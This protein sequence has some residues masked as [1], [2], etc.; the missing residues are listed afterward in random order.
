MDFLTERCIFFFNSFIKVCLDKA[1]PIQSEF[2][3]KIHLNTAIR[4]TKQGERQ[5]KIIQ[6]L[7]A[8]SCDEED[9]DSLLQILNSIESNILFPNDFLPFQLN[10]RK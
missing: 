3:K 9:I 1:M 7:K 2:V 4:M 5:E 8:V 10:P 6:H